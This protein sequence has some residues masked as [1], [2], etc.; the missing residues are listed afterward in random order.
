M[1]SI[2]ISFDRV[3]READAG[4]AFAF[5]PT[6]PAIALLEALQFSNAP[7]GRNRLDLRQRAEDVNPLRRELGIG[8]LTGLAGLSH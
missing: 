3:V 6:A 2:Q 1:V 5:S 8:H 7:P 4:D